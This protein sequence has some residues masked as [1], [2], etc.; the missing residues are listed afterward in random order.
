MPVSLRRVDRSEL[1]PPVNVV[2]GPLITLI[3]GERTIDYVAV[4]DGWAIDHVATP[5]SGT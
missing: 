5:M 3:R 4:R 2:D 1:M